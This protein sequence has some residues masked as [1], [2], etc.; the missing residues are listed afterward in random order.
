M[1]EKENRPLKMYLLIKDTIDLGHA[2]L[3]AAHAS[4]GG[5]LTF[6]KS[7]PGWDG[8]PIPDN[9]RVCEKTE[10]WA[11]ESFRKVVCKVTAEEFE[12]AKTF[13]VAGEDYRVMVE[14]GLGGEEV[15]IVFAPR[16]DWEPFF[17]TLKLYK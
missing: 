9:P 11:I 4:L 5:Y 1:K 10:E 7:Q 6:T 13:G 2:I 3:G 12:K 8:F 16:N 15:S 14:S 17:K